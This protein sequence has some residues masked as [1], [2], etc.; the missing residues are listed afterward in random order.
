MRV[1]SLDFH[2]QK[3]NVVTIDLSL[4][5]GLPSLYLLG[6]V[7]RELKECVPKLKSA[8]LS[9]GFKW[10]RTKQVVVEVRTPAGQVG[11]AA[12]LAIMVALLRA[13][14]QLEERDEKNDFFYVGE[15]SLDGKVCSPKWPKVVTQL[16]KER[17]ILSGFGFSEDFVSEISQLAVP[18]KCEVEEGRVAWQRPSVPD[19]YFSPTVAEFI[20]LV[21]AGEHPTLFAGPPGTGKTTL[22]DCI[23]SVLDDLSL[24]QQLELCATHQLYGESINWRPRIAPHHSSSA[25]A[26][27]GGGNPP[28]PGEISRA[29]GGLLFLDEYLEFSPQVQEALREP[30][31]RGQIRV[32]RGPKAAVFP[33]DFLLLAAT[34]LCSCGKLRP[35][36]NYSCSYSLS[37]CRSRLQRLSGPMLDRFHIL[38]LSHKW[39][40]PR[41][42]HLNK[43]RE[44]VQKAVQVRQQRG[45][46][47]A[48]G[49]LKAAE[50]E[51]HL[52]PGVLIGLPG[53]EGS[54][55]RRQSVLR[56]AQTLADL[57]G[58]ETINFEHI[59][60][61][62][63]YA[64]T[65]HHELT[66]LFA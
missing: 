63:G 8:F 9:Q 46:Q 20:A 66:Q 42:I 16:V 64:V 24:S 17:K 45:Q 31:E 22:V 19:V 3:L 13:T 38:G 1:Y 33:A 32:A 53:I 34:N 4:M 55:R 61:A 29:H 59:S 25:L 49:K 37:R 56:I 27:L 60:R 5:P 40:G 58:A 47:F 54:E 35:D 30:L 44:Q 36:G 7:S 18:L 26:L 48:N 15:L 57:D 2:Q 23:H 52:A 10:P 62:M 28:Q 50:L 11:R 14:G 21:A 12:E 41:T 39:T 6:D 43:V 65:P 51:A